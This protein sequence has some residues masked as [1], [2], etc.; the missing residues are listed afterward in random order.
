MSKILNLQKLASH[1]GEVEPAISI[2]SCDSH[3]C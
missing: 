1:V 3:S 2:S